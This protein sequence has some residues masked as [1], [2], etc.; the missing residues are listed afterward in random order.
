MKKL[1]YQDHVMDDLSSFMQ[2]VNDSNNIIQA[3]S[4][5]WMG[6]DIKVGFGG[7]P[8]YNNTIPGVP[9]VCMKVPTGG[10]KTYMAC[11]SLKRIFSFMPPDKPRMVIWLVPSDSILTQTLRA[12]RDP[13]HEYR[14]KLDTDFSGRVGVYTKDELLNGQNFSPDTVRSLS[15]LPAF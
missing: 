1:P 9:Y 8:P 13:N 10:G 2:K 3:W 6:K 12:L 5:Y 11:R 14:K 4:Q 7:L 15:S